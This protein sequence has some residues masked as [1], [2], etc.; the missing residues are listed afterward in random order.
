MA[1]VVI[2]PTSFEAR[3]LRALTASWG[4]TSASSGLKVWTLAATS[5][6]S[7]GV[8]ADVV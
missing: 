3:Y 7:I 8:R 6:L 5:N 4:S 1:Q 2:A